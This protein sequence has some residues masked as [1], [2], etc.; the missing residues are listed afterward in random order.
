MLFISGHEVEGGLGWANAVA[1]WALGRRPFFT[2]A[3]AGIGSTPTTE[4]DADA[5]EGQSDE[6]RDCARNGDGEER[7]TDDSCRPGVR[8]GVLFLHLYLHHALGF[9]VIYTAYQHYQ[10]SS[11]SK[12]CQ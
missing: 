9:Y 1:D 10:S 6:D 7:D 12:Q 3:I 4:I 11:L 8:D 2:D 5:L